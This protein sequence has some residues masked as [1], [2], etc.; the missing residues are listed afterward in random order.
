ML[1]SENYKFN[2][3]TQQT[4]GRVNNYTGNSVIKPKTVRASNVH[5]YVIINKTKVLLPQ[6]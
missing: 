2:F 5:F 4:G 3:S 6:P 1:I